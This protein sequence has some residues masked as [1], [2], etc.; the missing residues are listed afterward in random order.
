M[1][2]SSEVR[3]GWHHRSYGPRENINTYVCIRGMKR[4]PCVGVVSVHMRYI[5]NHSMEET[6]GGSRNFENEMFYKKQDYSSPGS[7]ETSGKGG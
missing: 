7:L 1:K 5:K 4:T 3:S 2:R 6:T